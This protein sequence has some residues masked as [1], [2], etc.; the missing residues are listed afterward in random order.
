MSLHSDTKTEA[1]LRLKA[2]RRRSSIASVMIA[3]LTVVLMGLILGLLQLPM[4]MMESP[5]IVTYESNISE[6]KELE[7][8]KVITNMDRRP[9]SPSSSMAKVI[10]AQTEAPTA[11]PVPEVEITVPSLDFG[12][13]D[14]FGDGWGSGSGSGGGGA[15]FG[16]LGGVGLVGRFFDLKQDRSG[17]PTKMAPNMPGE[18]DLNGE[19]NKAYDKALASLVSRGMNESALGTYFEA[20]KPLVL[21][22]LFIPVISAEEAPRAFKVSDKVQGR[23]WAVI[24]RG[25]VVA[26]E[27]GSYRF[28]GL[29]DDILVV[30]LKGRIVL[31]GSLEPPSRE[32]QDTRY[33]HDHL[34]NDWQSIVGRK[35]N[36]RERET[37]SIEL[38]IGE[39]PGG[40]FSGYLL[41][42]KTGI[43]YQ[44]DARGANKLPIFKLAPSETPAGGGAV[45]EVA[46]DTSWSVWSVQR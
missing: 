25:R 29:G 28:V 1:L 18:G 9:S 45:P 20:P 23:R 17:R 14:G 13:D 30:R 8:R 40:H 4:L 21:T 31:D 19:V 27:A 43:E 15:G 6:D 34:P 39:R 2:Q 3:I 32:S 35:F 11:V 12:G 46:P 37:L 22:Q 38:L 36:V 10:T 7:V 24:Y 5:T 42:E 33:P 41:L 44:K 26:P 16:T